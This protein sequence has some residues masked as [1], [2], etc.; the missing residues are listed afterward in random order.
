[1]SIII[2]YQF[3]SS[4]NIVGRIYNSIHVWH[5]HWLTVCTSKPNAR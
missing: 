4:L 3:L 1:M 2:L 5:Q